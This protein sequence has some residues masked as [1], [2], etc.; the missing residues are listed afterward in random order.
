MAN[1]NLAVNSCGLGT[2]DYSELRILVLDDDGFDRERLQRLS[3]TLPFPTR[4]DE[5][6]G[7]ASL[8]HQ[9]DAQI[10]DVIL[11]DY[12]LSAGDGM[13]ALEIINIHEVNRSA[14]HGCWRSPI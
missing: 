6:D 5:A 13:D 4:V 3:L 1:A 8:M 12:R 11:I 7:L 9:L 10:Y 14:D 2:K